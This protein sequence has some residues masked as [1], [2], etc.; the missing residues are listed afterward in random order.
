MEPK[1]NRLN[2]YNKYNGKRRYMFV[3]CDTSSQNDVQI[4]TFVIVVKVVVVAG[5]TIQKTNVA[6]KCVISGGRSRL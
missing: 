1:L 5:P 6:A 4:V 2:I 3:D